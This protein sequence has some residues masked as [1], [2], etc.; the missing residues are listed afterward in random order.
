MIQLLCEELAKKIRE[1]RLA[2]QMV[3]GGLAT[4]WKYNASEKRNKARYWDYIKKDHVNLIPDADLAVLSFFEEVGPTRIHHGRE[5]HTGKYETDLRLIC[6]ANTDKGV[7]TPV[8]TELL[9]K[10]FDKPFTSTIFSAVTV[11][12]TE[13]L[14]EDDRLFARYEYSDAQRKFL[15]KPYDAFGLRAKVRF[16]ICESVMHSGRQFDDSFSYS[17]L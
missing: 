13:L 11:T 14:P 8:L 7:L 6:W 17:Y 9:Q 5:R 16:S 12:F 2:E 10:V 15:Q 4:V 3:A 1:A